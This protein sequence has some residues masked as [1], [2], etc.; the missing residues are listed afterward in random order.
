MFFSKL[1]ERAG[2][3]DILAPI[4]SP[5]KTEENNEEGDDA[6]TNSKMDH[7]QIKRRRLDAQRRMEEDAESRGCFAKKQR[8]RY[9]YRTMDTVCDAVVVDVHF[10]DGP[11]HPYYVSIGALFLLL[12]NDV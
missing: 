6:V 2:L 8:V 11:E 12:D 7:E 4:T 1:A 3:L 10:D 9:H 5:W